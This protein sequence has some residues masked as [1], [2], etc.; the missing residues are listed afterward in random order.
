MASL[1]SVGQVLDQS[2]EHCRKHYKELLAIILWVVIASLPSIVGKVLEPL[3]GDQALQGGDWVSFAFSLI[4]AILV[5]VVSL[6]MY[7]ALTHTLDLQTLGRR[8]NLKEVYRQSWQDWGKYFLLSLCLGAIFLGLMLITAPGIIFLMLGGSENMPAWFSVIGTPLFFIGAPITAFFVIKYMVELA[9]A[10]FF[11]LLEDKSIP[12]SLT[13]SRQ[14]VKGRWWAT[15]LRFAIP[16]FIYF[17]GFFIINFV[18]LRAL[19]LLIG[20]ISNSSAFGVLVVYIVT[21]LVSIFL[22]VVITPFIVS[23]DYLLYTS[24]KKNRY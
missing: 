3:G 6:W 15:M 4:G 20:V 7:I 8:V 18:V 24:L 23:T 14:L 2:F 13:A 19:S 9:F 17:L 12:D 5:A 16:K 11:L 10:P 21:L 1:L 22:S